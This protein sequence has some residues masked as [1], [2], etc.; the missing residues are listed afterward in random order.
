MTTFG[1]A[2]M[3]FPMDLIP[4]LSFEKNSYKIALNEQKTKSCPVYHYNI[5]N[6]QR[7]ILWNLCK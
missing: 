1:E 2:L 4:S 6:Y 7:I 3:A 5:K